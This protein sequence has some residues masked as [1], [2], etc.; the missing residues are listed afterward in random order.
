MRTRIA[1]ESTGFPGYDL[2][3]RSAVFLGAVWIAASGQGAE[4]DLDRSKIPPPAERKGEY[5]ADVKPLLMR[6]LKCHNGEEQAGGLRLDGRKRALEGGDSGP[7]LRPGK[8]AE[9]L[10]V[11]MVSGALEGKMMP[12]PNEGTPFTADEIGLLR[13]W[14]DAGADWP[15]DE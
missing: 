12:P 2:G 13:S 7:L 3:R 10:L 8:S 4:G 11:Q 15:A 5:A 6:C 14:I 9:S 1:A